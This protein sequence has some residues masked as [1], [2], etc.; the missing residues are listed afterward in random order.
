MKFIRLFVTKIDLLI[1]QRINSITAIALFILIFCTQTILLSQT[2]QEIAKKSFPSVVLLV[3]EDLSG[4]PIS[5]GSGFFVANNK[6]VTNAHVIEGA[7]KGYAR[8]INN[9]SKLDILGYTA[10]DEVHDL[11]LLEIKNS[12]ATK[13]KLGDSDKLEVGEDVYAIGNP[14]GLEGTFSKGIISSIRDIDGHGIIQITAPISPGSSGGPLVNSRGDVIGIA[15]A[16]YKSGQNLNF[17]IPI[18][19]LKKLLDNSTTLKKLR[20]VSEN[21]KGKSIFNTIGDRSTDAIKWSNFLWSEASSNFTLSIKNNLDQAVKNIFCIVIFYDNTDSPI[22]FERIYH[23]DIIPA[24]LAKRIE[25]WVEAS[26]K[27]LT[28]K[29][30]IRVLDFEF[31]E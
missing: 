30:D 26:T 24:G 10:I 15:F 7:A 31:E 11:V 27:K 21:L 19:Y 8:L 28:R 17:A 20:V 14:Q 29:I 6:I 3:M 16:S 25:S 4:Q 12:T 23:T 2:A 18:K 1:I 13:L 9:K 5:I 22:D